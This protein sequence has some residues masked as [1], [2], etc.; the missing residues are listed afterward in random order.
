MSNN[1]TSIQRHAKK[2]EELLA[3][4]KLKGNLIGVM[5]VSR[6]GN[7]VS[8]NFKRDI[9]KTTFS[10]MCALAIESADTLRDILSE[11][12]SLKII[13]E[14]NNCSIILMKC[15]NALFLVFFVGNSSNM[16]PVIDKIDDYIKKIILLYTT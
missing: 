1:K 13:T 15:S 2:L 5:L 10:A 8:N 3:E 12:T 16:D 11:G 6:E 9:D 4:L 7:V 14:L